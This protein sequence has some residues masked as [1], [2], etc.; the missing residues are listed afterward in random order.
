MVRPSQRPSIH[1]Q[2]H[3]R[4]AV[5]SL[6]SAAEVRRCRPAE[7]VH[8]IE[9]PRTASKS[10]PAGHLP[11]HSELSEQ[12]RPALQLWKMQASDR[13]IQTRLIAPPVK[14]QADA[15]AAG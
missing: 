2:R 14:T 13:V 15:S 6:C 4:K 12:T 8:A 5:H 1:A 11:T 10:P 3:S 7:P 9:S